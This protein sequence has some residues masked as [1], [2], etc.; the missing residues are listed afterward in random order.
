MYGGLAGK[1]VTF[2]GESVTTLDLN[3]ANQFVQPPRL[4]HGKGA[5]TGHFIIFPRLMGVN[6]ADETKVSYYLDR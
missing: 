4:L 5:S 1:T 6:G 3:G 2:N